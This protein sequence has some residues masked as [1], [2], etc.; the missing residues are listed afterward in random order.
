MSEQPSI[1][2]PRCSRTSYNPNDIAQGYC[3][4]CH[5]WTSD[6]Q[7]GD[8][9]L[10]P[11]VARAFRLTAM[12][13]HSVQVGLILVMGGILLAITFEEWSVALATF[14]MWLVCL[15]VYVRTRRQEMKLFRRRT[16]G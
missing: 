5:W 14:V 8:V 6:A 7:L 1:T 4:Y 16:G 2:C 13:R 11:R 10:S 9:D 3:G 15:V 12:A